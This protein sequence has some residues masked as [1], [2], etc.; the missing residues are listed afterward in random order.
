MTAVIGEISGNVEAASVLS[1]ESAEAAD[2]GGV[3]LQAAAAAMEKIA[4]GS[5]SVE[6]KMS[7]LARRSE[8]IARWSA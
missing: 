8:D 1:R 4:A 3:V 2:Q 7:S 6:E 5:G